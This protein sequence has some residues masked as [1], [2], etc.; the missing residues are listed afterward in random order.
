MAEHPTIDDVLESFCLYYDARVKIDRTSR[1]PNEERAEL[2][3]AINDAKE[4]AKMSLDA[5]IDRR[6]AVAKK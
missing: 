2:F 5:Y 6:I 4:Y 3:E 1:I